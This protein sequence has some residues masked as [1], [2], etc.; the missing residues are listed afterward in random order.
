MYYI[1]M[2][3]SLQALQTNG[4]FFFQ[5]SESFFELTKFYLNNSGIGF[6]HVWKGRHLC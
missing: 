5:I 3:S 6:M 1:S 4:K 2:D